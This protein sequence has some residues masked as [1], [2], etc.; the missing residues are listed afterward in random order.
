MSEALTV[1]GWYAALT[2]GA[3]ALL[4]LILWF[5]STITRG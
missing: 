2:V 5:L 4:V 3:L 1:L